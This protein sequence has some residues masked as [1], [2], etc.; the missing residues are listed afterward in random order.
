MSFISRIFWWKRIPELENLVEK[1][2]E[3]IKELGERS[4]ET[5]IPR[6]NQE[7]IEKFKNDIQQISSTL[8][9]EKEKASSLEREVEKQQKIIKELGERSKETV[10]P[11]NK[12]E[13]IEKFKNDIQQISSTL[14]K[15][16]EKTSSLEREIRKEERINNE[17]KGEIERKTSLISKHEES[18]KTFK[19]KLAEV[20][21]RYQEVLEKFE[22]EKQTAICLEML[23]LDLDKELGL[24]DIAKKL[25][26]EDEPPEIMIRS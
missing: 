13:E 18:I 24:M 17:L 20:N 14:E 7:E 22:K 21:N 4:K 8:E 3:I 5:V 25:E 23:I 16:R 15:E 26:L 1:Q 11:D 10:I 19:G 2:H 6:K 9:K 12:Q